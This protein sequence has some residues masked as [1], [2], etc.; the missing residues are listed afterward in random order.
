MWGT[1]LT[2]R[3]MLATAASVAGSAAAARVALAQGA[4]P[5]GVHSTAPMTMQGGPPAGRQRVDP[6]ANGFDPSVVA[7][8]FDHGKTRRLAGGRVLREWEIVA[9]DKEIEVLPGVKIAAWTFNGR[10]PGPTLRCREG[11]L[12]RIRFVNDG[13]H[14]HTMHFHG[15]HP[16]GMDGV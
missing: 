8:G 6:A 12:L 3:G 4:P 7:R 15:I 2:R 16:A 11:D 10:V 14:P 1:R 9:Y 5:A 13:T